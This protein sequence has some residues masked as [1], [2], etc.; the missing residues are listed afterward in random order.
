MQSFSE[1]ND[2]NVKSLYHQSLYRK[3]STQGSEQ[4]SSNFHHNLPPK[5]Q[6][7][8]SSVRVASHHQPMQHSKPNIPKSGNMHL[9]KKKVV[10]SSWTDNQKYSSKLSRG[11]YGVPTKVVRSSYQKPNNSKS[12]SSRTY[13]QV[14]DKQGTL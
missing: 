6:N 3:A 2:H 13:T 5:R 1:N 7:S 10:R 12:F 11:S 8:V 4:I 9:S 14:V